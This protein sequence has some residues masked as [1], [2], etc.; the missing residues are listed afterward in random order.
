MNL[1]SYTGASTLVA[2]QAGAEVLHVDASKPAIT[3]ARDNQNASGLQAKKI[4]W[5]PDDAMVFVQR[6]IR[7]GNHYDAII[8]DPPK[9][10]RGTK[11]EVW[12]F[13]DSISKLLLESVKLLSKNPLFLLVNAYA[14]PISPTTLQNVLAGVTKNLKGKVTAGELGLQESHEKR[15]LPMSLFARWEM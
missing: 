13:E 9:Y 14:V 3:W 7:R 15:I 5:I 1:F 2:A 8:M 12:Q 4:R 11:G 10:G 6:E